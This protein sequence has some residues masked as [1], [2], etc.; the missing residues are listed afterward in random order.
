VGKT[1]QGVGDL[2]GR[3][4]T[5]PRTLCFITH[6]DEVLLLRGAPDKAIWPDQYNG[7]GGHVECGEDVRSAALREICEETSLAVDELRLRGVINVCPEPPGPG[8]MLFVFTAR[9]LEREVVSS[10]EGTPVWVKK[11]QVEELELVE[12]LPILL[13][14]VLGMEPHDAPFFAH[15]SY[16]SEDQLMV[17]FAR[18]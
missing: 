1:D 8:V 2:S 15:Y 4:L 5:V 12:D 18:R 13:P 7:I 3:Y 10:P 14:R 16:D 9:A 6:G 17:T 11:D